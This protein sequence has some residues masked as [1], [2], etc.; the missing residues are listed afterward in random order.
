MD[1]S[2]FSHP[3]FSAADRGDSGF[4]IQH[5]TSSCLQKLAHVLT[6]SRKGDSRGSFW[7]C[8]D[9]LSLAEHNEEMC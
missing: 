8:Q 7:E 2:S 1:A 4:A 3:C 5:I 6:C 9:A